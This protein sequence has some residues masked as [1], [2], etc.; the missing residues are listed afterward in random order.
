MTRLGALRRS[1]MVG[2]A[3]AFTTAIVGA[4]TG[5]AAMADPSDPPRAQIR[6]AG[7]AEAV[8]DRYIVVLKDGKASPSEVR[9]TA[10]AL[11]DTNGGSVRRVFTKALKGYSATMNR[12]QAERLAADPDVAYVEQV[13]RYSATDTQSSPPWGLDRID[14][15]TAKTNSSYTYATTGAGVT[16]YILDTGID[17]NHEDFGGRASYGYDA[18]EQ[19]A[20]AQDCDG[21]GTHV[22]GTVG[23]TKYGVA[24]GVKLVAVRVLDCSGSGTSEQILSGIDWVTANAVKPAVANMSLGFNGTNQAVN[25]AVTRSIAAG[26][27]Y[28]VAAGNSMQDACGVSPANVPNAITVGA[29][30]KVDFRAWFSN[31]GRCLDT[32]APGVSIVSAAMGTTSGAVAMNGTSMASPHVA[33]AAALLLQAHP[34]WTPQQVRDSI[35]TTGIGGA[36]HDTMGSID[37]LLY[38]GAVQPARS[39]YG[40]KARVNGKFVTAESAG[41][42]P[43]IARGAALGPWEKYD[44]VDA[45]GGL[46]GLRAKINGKFVTAESGG[47]RP[48]IARAASIGAWEKFQIINNT[49][50]TVSLKATI[51]GRYVT[52]P[53]TTVPLIASKTTIG[54]AEK[55]DFEAPAPVVS[56]KSQA[57]GKYVMAENYGKL[58]LIAKA[59]AVGSWEKFEIVNVGNGFFGLRALVNGKFVTAESAGANPLIARGTAIGTWEKFDVL[60][61]N[62]DGSIYLRAYINGKAVTAGSAG[63]SQLIASR[64]IDWNSETLGL[65]VGEKFV[66][67]VI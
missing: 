10:S 16:A 53:S 60:D 12:R 5:G 3:L 32:F 15:T 29:T 4:A 8:P 56:I 23:G 27:T 35:V 37:R 51:N 44:V 66:V 47:A 36:V 14:Q 63:T 28:A 50:G 22:A 30:D 31:Y 57:N 17:L 21:H 49:D 19:D 46:V 52:A 9:A 48:L 40:L 55:F 6:G 20:V 2:I 7:T 65:G 18:V 39:S 34:T 64:T 61:Y 26:I 38:V 42:K 1:A 58:P 13:Q 45:G 54:T 11:A 41:T 43:L 62:P 67:A 59:G 33:G 24:K 25:D